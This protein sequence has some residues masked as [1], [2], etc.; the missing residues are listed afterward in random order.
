MIITITT[1]FY[2]NSIDP[3]KFHIK[4]EYGKAGGVY[5]TGLRNKTSIVKFFKSE[6]FKLI[7]EEDR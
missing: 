7:S 6:V 5:E 1:D 2:K 4:V 3:T